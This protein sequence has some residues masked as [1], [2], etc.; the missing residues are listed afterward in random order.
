MP[1]TV[2]VSVSGVKECID[3]LRAVK[4]SMR[5]QL[6]TGAM[7]AAL[8]PTL[9]EARSNVPVDTGAYRD[10]LGV[11]VKSYRGGGI[12]IGLM[13]PRYG[14]KFVLMHGKGY[15]PT[16]YAHV[17]EFGDSRG[18]PAY[19]P[20]RRA[21]LSTRGSFEVTFASELWNRLSARLALHGLTP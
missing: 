10:S 20:L 18:R 13:G 1:V 2:V 3:K 15:G 11:K 19:A 14:N 5:G 16:R 8:Q 9:A 7:R 17:I 12:V 21:W 4:D 6:V